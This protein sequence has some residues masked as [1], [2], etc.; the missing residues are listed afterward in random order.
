[1]ATNKFINNWTY[2]PTQDLIEDLV[3]ESIAFGGVN[4]MY[5]PRTMND[6]DK[7][8]GEPAHIQFNSNYVDIEI[9]INETLQFGGE[10][11][12]LS[13]FGVEIRDSLTFWIS[14][15]RFADE[16]NYKN[17]ANTELM[18][19]NQPREGDLIYLPHL[20]GNFFQIMFVET[21]KIFF[22]QGV[23]PVYELACEKFEYS[24][25]TFATGNTLIDSIS[26][27]YPVSNTATTDPD[28]TEDFDDFS[29]DI[30]DF[31]EDNPFSE[32]F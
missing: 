1:M 7:I 28:D 15:K 23:C 16:T 8:F 10:G 3:A 22:A 19:S 21:R 30:I 9:Y 20:Q 2:T 11:E 18:F 25:E 14:K 6:I 24:G 32:K 4:A 29:N 27:Q 26:T 17:M 5:L 31:S 12:L 13:K